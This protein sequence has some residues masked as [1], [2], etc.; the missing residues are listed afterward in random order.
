M[1]N[2]A[3][4]LTVLAL[5][6]PSCRSNPIDRH[7]AEEL[8]AAQAEEW[9]RGDIPAFVGFY[10]QGLSFLGADGLVRGGADLV[11]RYQE[12]YPD[13]AARGSLRFGVLD[14]RPLGGDSAL[15][16][17]T[18]HIERREP[19]EGYFTLVLERT[20][21]GVRITHDHTTAAAE[22]GR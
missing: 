10:S 19:A 22:G 3:L 8:L 15:L 16:L 13:A 21:E 11:Q 4:L 17:G 9:N 5:I 20:S 6:L 2:P 12:R 18:Y 7:E 1:N 14:F